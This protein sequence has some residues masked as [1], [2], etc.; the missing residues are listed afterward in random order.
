[1][2]QYSSAFD[3]EVEEF[4]EEPSTELPSDD[5]EGVLECVLEET[6]VDEA[7]AE[8]QPDQGGSTK[9][10]EVGHPP[11]STVHGPYYYFYQG[12]SRNLRDGSPTL[13]LGLG[14][15]LLH[16]A[17]CLAAAEDCQQMFLHPVNVRCLLREYGSLEASPD[18]ITATVVEIV[19]HSVTEVSSHTSWI[20][21]S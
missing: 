14:P 9:Q 5:P 8:A 3:D 18:S 12:E 6:V 16:P 15:T 2:L 13:L 19:G 20:V 21:L 4:P 7:A 1:M 10:V 11:A 17:V